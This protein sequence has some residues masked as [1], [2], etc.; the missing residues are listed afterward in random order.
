MGRALLCAIG[1]LTRL[2]VPS[3]TL[4]ER[5][6]AK[7]AAFF[8]WVGGLIAAC[9]WL[10][11]RGCASTGPR[12]CALLMVAGWALITGGL[13]LDGVADT[14]DGLSGGRGDRA[15]ALE[16]MRDSRIGAHGA[17][18]LVLVLLA[19]WAA[20]E[21]VL[22]GQRI[23]WLAV[24][25]IARLLSTV[26]LAAFPYAREQGLGKA[27]VSRVG[28]RELALASLSL[29]PLSL[30]FGVGLVLPSL[31]GVAVAGLL[32]MRMRLLLGGLTG[33][34]HGAAIELCEVAMLLALGALDLP[35][36]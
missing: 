27:F 34:M 8:P 5:D 3:V 24:P 20:L 10:V 17:T 36:R 30:W 32:V 21:R 13:H 16:I 35:A 2:P 9:L 12:L 33:D 28:V 19:K 7:S 14:F 26:L 1:F 4:S 15:R 23:G 29:V 11:E 18:A 25:V 22:G 31:V 6:V